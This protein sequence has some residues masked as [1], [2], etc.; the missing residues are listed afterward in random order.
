VR[1]RRKNHLGDARLEGRPFV[2]N[3]GRMNIG[4]DLVVTSR[5]VPSHLVT[6]PAGV[7]TIGDRVRIAHGVSINAQAEIVI[8]DDVVL[9]PYVTI[10]DVDFHGIH[11]RDAPSAARPIRIGRGVRLGAGVVVLRGAILGD[12]A[13]VAAN[14]VVSRA[15]PAGAH[16]SGVPARPHA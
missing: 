9:G 5:P 16:A 7:L 2:D 4:R 1:L 14:S 10:L 8:G 13:V 11:D 3:G 12:G 6:G 15:V